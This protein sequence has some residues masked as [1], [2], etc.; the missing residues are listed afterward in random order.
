MNEC[1]RAHNFLILDFN[2]V[3]S[4]IEF[5]AISPEKRLFKDN[6]FENSEINPTSFR[7]I[8]FKAISKAIDDIALNGSYGMSGGGANV[9]RDAS[10]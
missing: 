8:E 7:I 3:S 10:L 2:N 1:K 5:N 9:K 6:S 4:I